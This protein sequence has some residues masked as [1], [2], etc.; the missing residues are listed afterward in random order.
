[1][2]QNYD[3]GRH[4]RVERSRCLCIESGRLTNSR[5]SKCITSLNLEHAVFN[6]FTVI[7][8]LPLLY[9]TCSLKL[10]CN[11]NTHASECQWFNRDRID[12]HASAGTILRSTI[13]HKA[14]IP[15]APEEQ[16]GEC[17]LQTATDDERQQLSFSTSRRRRAAQSLVHTACAPHTRVGIELLSRPTQ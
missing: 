15:A 10:A 9:V 13:T 12:T 2:G 4:A 5:F 14:T 11:G 8:G 16:K 3:N 17:G 6:R 1:V 7:N